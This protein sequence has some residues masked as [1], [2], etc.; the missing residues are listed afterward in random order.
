M[1]YHGLKRRVIEL[2]KPQ[3]SP[4]AG[5]VEVRMDSPQRVSPDGD[6]V[7]EIEIHKSGDTAM[8][9]RQSGPV[10]KDLSEIVAGFMKGSC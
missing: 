10:C 8:R 2:S 6:V 7:T 1:D 3:Q 9:I 4:S 5:F